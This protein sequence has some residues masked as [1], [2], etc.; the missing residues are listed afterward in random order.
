M[1]ML[2]YSV[3]AIHKAKTPL[4]HAQLKHIQ[5]NGSGQINI[6]AKLSF[7][8]YIQVPLTETL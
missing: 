4:G 7:A 8:M 5:S 3:V 6:L 1:P 2:S